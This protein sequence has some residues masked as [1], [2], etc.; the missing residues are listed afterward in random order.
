MPALSSAPALRAAVAD[1][2]VAWSALRNARSRVVAYEEAIK[3]QCRADDAYIPSPGFL[4]EHAR[5][6]AAVASA[7]AA[8]AVASGRVARL[9]RE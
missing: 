2:S 5:L 7:L 8:Y 3:A 6:S 9:R 4:A 1:S